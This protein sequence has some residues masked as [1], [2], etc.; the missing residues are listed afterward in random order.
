ML[1]PASLTDTEITPFNPSALITSFTNCSV[2]RPLRAVSH[3]NG[4]HGMRGAKLA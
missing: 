1:A 4:H 3:G 2:S